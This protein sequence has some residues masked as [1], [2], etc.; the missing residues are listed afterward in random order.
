[1]KRIVITLLALFM[2]FNISGCIKKIDSN[3]GINLYPAFKMD[4]KSKLWGY[5]NDSGE[6]VIEPKYDAAFDFSE[7]GFAQI[8][9][10]NSVGLV[11]D[12]GEEIL[13][14]K[15]KEIF[16]HKNG[17]IVAHDGRVFHVF[18][19]EGKEQFVSNEYMYIGPYSEGLF[20]VGML[21]DNGNLIIGYA[22]KSGKRVI[23]PKFIRAYDFFEKKT[24]VMANDH[25]HYI[26]DLEGNI[27]KELE[28]NL[29]VPS[30]DR[31]TYLI[32]NNN[33][34]F[35][36]LNNEGDILIEP[37][38]NDAQL[39]ED[40][41]A[42]VGIKNEES[43]LYGVIN[44]NGEYIIEPKYATITSLGKGYFGVSEKT[45]KAGNK[46]AIAK[47]NGEVITDFLYYDL[48]KIEKDMIT[49][50]D[51]IQTYIVDLKGNKVSKLPVLK[52]NG[53]LKFNGRIAKATALNRLSYYNDKG[54]LIWEESNDYFLRKGALVL[55]KQYSSGDKIN[56]FY[57]V[58][59]GL[60]DKTVEENINKELYK[61]FVEDVEESI[62]KDSDKKYYYY[63]TTYS[64]RKMNDLL[65]I[66]KISEYYIEGELIKNDVGRVFNI[67][68]RNGK[69]F[70][71]KDLFMEDANYVEALSAKVR[72]EV[73]IKI[74]EG[75]S[76]YKVVDFKE[77]K[78]DQDFIPYMDKIEIVLNPSQ[79]TSN[80]ETFPRFEISHGSMQS[81]LD[82]ELDFWW[83]YT[84]NRG[85]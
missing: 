54:K 18:N 25:M 53:E 59:E 8:H 74:M 52:G 69:F 43:I 60:A 48:S 64:A 63:N 73:G 65:T 23:E 58:V 46:Y 47:E 49:A 6:F 22:D 67:S 50:Y 10:Y 85:F 37:K 29:V 81:I 12:K 14:P 76:E 70:N 40:G 2:I 4:E 78:E 24:V 83:T 5:I 36:Y 1:M 42:I 55:E 38:F 57:P 21:S 66:Q 41:N 71:L 72:E 77:I 34:L 28:Y 84:N 17:Y 19:Y 26:I 30:E 27:I 7:E 20:A 68:L 80:T 31:Q 15:Y 9:R 32:G 44:L 61:R 16:N 79:I 3:E 33:D 35:G 51:G 45:N 62:D 13:Q 82:M 39:F 56:I 75:I 11:N